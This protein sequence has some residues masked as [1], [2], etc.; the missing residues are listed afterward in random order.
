MVD[1][2]AFLMI[3]PQLPPAG[4]PII[5]KLTR[6]VTALYRTSSLDRHGGY[7][8]FHVCSCGACSDNR[9]HYLPGHVLTNSLCV[10]Y[11]AFHRHELTTDQL[12]E[13][14]NILA[15]CGSGGEAEPTEDELRPPP[16]SR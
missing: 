12:G 10:H 8:G 2:K 11:V 4:E 1:P 15:E 9:D 16:R 13:I 5:D 3:E 14:A 7:R 6:S